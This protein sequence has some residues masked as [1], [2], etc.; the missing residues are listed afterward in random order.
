MEK[1]YFVSSNSEK[2]KEAQAILGVPIEIADIEIDEVQSMSLKTVAR[3]KVESA[4]KIVGEPVIVDDVSFEIEAFNRFP[5]P[6]VKFFFNS[7]GN[8]GVLKLME[9]E[10]NRRVIVQSAIGYHDGKKAHVFVGTIKGTLSLEERGT[11]GWGFD[12]IVIPDGHTKTIA[13]LG[14]DHKNKNSHRAASLEM[15]KKYLRSQK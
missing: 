9:K 12:P 11:D 13:E 5:G 1:I 15:L 4:F 2:V 7:L 8:N 6:L 14:V 3:K 10:D